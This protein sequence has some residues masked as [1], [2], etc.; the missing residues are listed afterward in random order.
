MYKSGL[1]REKVL[2]ENTRYVTVL[3]EVEVKDKS[4]LVDT[5]GM[6]Q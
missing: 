5:S 4:V 2:L 6:R 3:V 1:F